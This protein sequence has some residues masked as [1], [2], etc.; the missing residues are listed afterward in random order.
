MNV[1]YAEPGTEGQQR[2]LKLELKLIADVGLVGMP[3]AGK[4]T[5]LRAISAARPKVADYPFTTLD[6]QL[7]IAELQGYRRIVVADIPGLIEGAQH[8]AG[9]GHAFLKHIER[10]KTIIHMLDMYPM[11]ESDPVQ[12]Y[13]T[14]RA[15]L[16]AF[17]PALANKR[18]IIAAN[19]MDLAIDDDALNRLMNELPD[20]EIFPISG[21]TRQGV[22][23]VL[24]TIWNV[25]QEAKEATPGQPGDVPAVGTI[26]AHSLPD[27]PSGD[28]MASPTDQT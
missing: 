9:L 16:E 13:R 10:T 21:A 25:L 1:R 2:R 11:D 8:G 22:E 19:K 14:I 12:N 17:S 6:P 7:G 3:N 18:E 26:Q 5:L 4:S 23:S 28:P 20:K 24:E 15:E 27:D